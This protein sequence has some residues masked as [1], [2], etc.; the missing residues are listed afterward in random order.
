MNRRSFRRLKSNLMVGLMMLAV[1]AAVLPLIHGGVPPPQ[2][3]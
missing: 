3:K 1:V 2:L